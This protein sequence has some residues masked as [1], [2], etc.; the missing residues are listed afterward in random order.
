MLLKAHPKQAMWHLSTLCMSISAARKQVGSC[1]CFCI[2]LN[3]RRTR[4]IVILYKNFK[5]RNAPECLERV[6]VL[7]IANDRTGV[8]TPG[9]RLIVVPCRYFSK[10]LYAVFGKDLLCETF[11]KIYV[12]FV[13]VTPYSVPALSNVGYVFLYIMS[14]NFRPIIGVMC[15]IHHTVWPQ[16]ALVDCL[17]YSLH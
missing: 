16:T 11:P 12:V 1:F 6:N 15:N 5:T 9:D 8:N 17:W 13:L 10:Q 7:P 14:W 4:S 2:L 3:Y